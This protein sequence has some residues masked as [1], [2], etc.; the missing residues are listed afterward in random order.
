MLLKIIKFYPEIFQ[1]KVFG[2]KI[3]RAVG[4]ILWH[5]FGDPIKFFSTVAN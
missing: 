1:F 3:I 2:N 5:I 4:L